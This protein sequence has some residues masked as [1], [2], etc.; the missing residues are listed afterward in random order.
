MTSPHKLSK[1]RKKTS[2]RAMTSLVT[3]W[4][5]VIATITGVVLYITPQGRIANL[6][7]THFWQFCELF[8]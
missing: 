1:P 7:M 8:V 4:A 6:F 3:T 5:F 2:Y